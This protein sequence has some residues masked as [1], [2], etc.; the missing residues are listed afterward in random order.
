MRNHK[1]QREVVKTRGWEDV[2]KDGNQIDSARGHKG[3]SVDRSIV[4]SGGLDKRWDEQLAG[5]TEREEEPK[6]YFESPTITAGLLP[7]AKD[8]WGINP[9]EPQCTR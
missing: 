3:G 7:T 9:N 4:A 8:Q 2:R 5:G 1:E 6:E